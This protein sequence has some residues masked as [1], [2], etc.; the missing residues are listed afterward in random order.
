MSSSYDEASLEDRIAEL[1]SQL[2]QQEE[3]IRTLGVGISLSSFS[4]F[5]DPLDN[6]FNAPEFWEVVVPDNSACHAD[7]GKRYRASLKAA[8]GDRELIRKAMRAATACHRAC[9]DLP[10]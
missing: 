8:N 1:E 5:D 10:F 6:F 3:R 9:G 4:V 2:K 7:C